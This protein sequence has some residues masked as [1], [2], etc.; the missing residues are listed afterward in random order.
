MIASVMNA[1]VVG[2]QRG[3][4]QLNQSAERIGQ[5]SVAPIEGGP[6]KRAA[7]MVEQILAK[8][9]VQGSSKIIQ[10]ASETLGTLVDIKV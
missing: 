4:D 9:Q 6:Q 1:G 8:I 10:T 7:P 3:Y 5:A 2:V